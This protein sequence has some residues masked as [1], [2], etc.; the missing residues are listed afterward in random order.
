MAYQFAQLLPGLTQDEDNT[1]M[2]T[3]KL[4][5]LKDEISEIRNRLGDKAQQL[6]F[7]SAAQRSYDAADDLTRNETLTAFRK[8]EEDLDLE[9]ERN[10]TLEKA[11]ETIWAEIKEAH[12]ATDNDTADGLLP[13]EM[14]V[15]ILTWAAPM[16][17]AIDEL[18]NLSEEQRRRVK[19]G[20]ADQERL[21]QAI[22]EA[23]ETAD[24]NDGTGPTA[25]LESQVKALQSKLKT[26]Q[27][28]AN[29]ADRRAR[30]ERDGLSR[31]LKNHKKAAET[32]AGQEEELRGELTALKLQNEQLESQKADMEKEMKRA[33]KTYRNVH[34]LLSRVVNGSRD[35]APDNSSSDSGDSSEHDDPGPL[36][37][38]DVQLREEIKKHLNSTA[39]ELDAALK[40][41]EAAERSYEEESR[42]CRE[43]EDLVKKWTSKSNESSKEVIVLQGKMTENDRELRDRITI[44]RTECDDLKTSVDSFKEKLNKANKGRPGPEARARSVEHY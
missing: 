15:E 31:E 32:A 28:E 35:E 14:T 37:Q 7:A 5:D 11:I 18:P 25:E 13:T 1:V 44:L 41:A 21:F 8:A 23:D 4:Q 2:C 34:G 26:L 17:H 10:R 9:I 12:G 36:T 43:L 33:K 38:D 39:S 24:K 3:G 16:V 27:G 29:A 19:E 20:T 42:Q 40:R 22:K 6:G 30:D